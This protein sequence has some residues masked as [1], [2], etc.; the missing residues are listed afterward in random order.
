MKEQFNPKVAQNQRTYRKSRRSNGPG[1][2]RGER[3]RNAKLNW[4]LVDTIRGMGLLGMG[5]KRITAELAADGFLFNER[6][7][8]NALY[9]RTW[10][11][12]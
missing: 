9:Y 11:K 2:V 7:V 10:N 6:T 12:R 8:S 4:G 5:P 1:Q 3:C